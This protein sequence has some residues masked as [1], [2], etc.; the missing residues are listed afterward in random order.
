MRLLPEWTEYDRE[1]RDLQERVARAGN[2]E[3]ATEATDTS[4][5]AVPARKS[6]L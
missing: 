1:V 4:A 5:S 2:T 3:A 6:E